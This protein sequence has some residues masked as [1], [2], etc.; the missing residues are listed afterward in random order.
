MQSLGRL[1]L[2]AAF[3][4]SGYAAFVYLACRGRPGLRL[5]RA[6]TACAV[7]AFAALSGA[8]A[9]LAGALLAKDFTFDYVAQYSS[10][11]LAWHYSL[12]ALWVGQGGSLLLWAWILAGLALAFRFLP[13]QDAH[14][15][16]LAFGVVMATLWFLVLVLVFAADPLKPSLSAPAEGLGL[17]P[18]LQHPSMLIHPPVVF[19]AYAAWTFPFA[20]AAAALVLGKCGTAWVAAARPWALVAWTVLLAGLVLGAQWAYE[21]LGWGGYWSWDPVENGSLLPWLTGTALIHCLLAW[22]HQGHLKKTALGLAFATFGLCLFATFLTRSGIFSS[23]HAFSQSPIGWLF[24]AFTGAVLA[25]GGTLISVR[26]RWLRPR[27]ALQSVL[28]RETLLILS[29]YTLIALTLAVLGGTVVAPLSSAVFGRT[30]QLEPGFYNSALAPVGLVVL[31]AAAPVPLLRWGRGPGPV[32]RRVLVWGVA[33]SV[34]AA[35]VG[36]GAGLRHAAALAVTGLCAFAGISLVGHMILRSR[37]L[38]QLGLQGGRWGAGP[39]D[40][41]PYAAYAVHIGFIALAVGITGSSLGSRRLE[42]VLSEGEEICWNHHRIRYAERVERS[43]PDKWIAETVLQV[44]RDGA[45]PVTL[46]PARH[47]HLLQNEWTTEVAIHST[48]AGDFYTVLNGGLDGGQASLTFVVNPLIR[49]IWVGALVASGGAVAAA[50]PAKR[51]GGVVKRENDRPC[52]VAI[53][54]TPRAA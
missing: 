1:C 15:R 35:A 54:Q 40:R 33:A 3:V 36:Y 52:S 42:V 7:A 8:V 14:L 25:G 11:L 45:A 32:Q 17:G 31:A 19:C 5:S 9:V 29:T 20:L 53:A 50:W 4:C 34:G 51:A 46:R 18:L 30:V 13:T 44:S 28:A 12:S 37:R 21:E 49:W 22:R 24:L 26:R 38:R 10:R 39:G 16:D 43:L 47:L 41:R 48:W 2:P 6:G 27:R 23:V